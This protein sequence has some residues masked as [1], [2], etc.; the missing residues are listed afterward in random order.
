MLS[1]FL[2]LFFFSV[3]LS[4][5]TAQ[6]II[7]TSVS[8]GINKNPRSKLASD[9]SYGN[10]SIQDV[11][12]NFIRVN[13]LTDNEINYHNDKKI[14]LLDHTVKAHKD[15]YNYNY[16]YVLGP[17]D[18]INI[19]LT[20]SDDID[21]TYKIDESGMIDLP[22][23]GVSIFS[24]LHNLLIINPSLLKSFTNLLK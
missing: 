3:L 20:D 8:T 2:K 18:I 22:V 5:C 12:I 7:E 24:P 14:D 11:E 23:A 6:S 16:E 17:S 10:Y 19:N 13:K 15:V 1:K 21:D 4:S 9:K